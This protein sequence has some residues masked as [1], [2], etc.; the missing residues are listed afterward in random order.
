MVFDKTSIEYQLNKEAL[1][2]MEE[3]VPMTLS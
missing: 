2:E 3:V 1:R